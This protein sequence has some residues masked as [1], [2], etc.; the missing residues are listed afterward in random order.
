MYKDAY[1]TNVLVEKNIV[2]NRKETINLM[3]T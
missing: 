1:N 2:K 3:K